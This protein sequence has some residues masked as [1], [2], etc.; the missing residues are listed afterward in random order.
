MENPKSRMF[1]LEAMQKLRDAG[2]TIK[3]HYVEAT[4]GDHFYTEEHRNLTI[5]IMENTV[6]AVKVYA[7]LKMKD[8]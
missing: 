6:N 3:S 1:Y 2:F 8:E 4:R 7:I 5:D